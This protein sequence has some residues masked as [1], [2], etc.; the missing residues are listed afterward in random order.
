MVRKETKTEKL[1]RLKKNALARSRRAVTKDAL[2]KKPKDPQ[3]NGLTGPTALNE[4]NEFGALVDKELEQVGK[5]YLAGLSVPVNT[6]LT[7]L[8][9]D[10]NE[11]RRAVARG[12][13]P[14]HVHKLALMVAVTA[15]RVTKAY[16]ERNS[17][18]IP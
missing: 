13:D 7:E 9:V 3:P 2:S 18:R 12:R 10:C 17:V 11:L 14:N 6:Y 16:C 8:G 1:K 4:L 15:A 5:E